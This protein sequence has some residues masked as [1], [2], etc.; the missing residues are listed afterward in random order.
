LKHRLHILLSVLTCIFIFSCI[1]GPDINIPDEKIE[2][3][4]PVVTDAQ[5][6]I[7]IPIVLEDV[8]VNQ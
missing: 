8:F 4:V 2:Y 5:I 6:Q 1:D 3:D 7:E